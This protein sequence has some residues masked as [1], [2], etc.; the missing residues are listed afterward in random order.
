[1]SAT[2]EISD[3]QGGRLKHWH[4][5]SVAGFGRHAP[6]VLAPASR[7]SQKGFYLVQDVGGTQP[8][9]SVRLDVG[10]RRKSAELALD[11]L[12]ESYSR[13]ILEIRTDNLHPDRETLFRKLNRC[14]GCR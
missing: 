3:M 9:V 5:A 12:G 2:P 14:G 4:S 6:I 1:M 11:Q 8:D 10:R 7:T 13:P